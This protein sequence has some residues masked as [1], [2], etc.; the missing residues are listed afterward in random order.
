M[1][2]IFK[3]SIL[4][5]LTLTGYSFLLL[6]KTRFILFIKFIFI[7]MISSDNVVD[8]C[9]FVLMCLTPL[10]AILQLYRGIILL[11]KETGGAG[12]NHRPVPSH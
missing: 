10:S 5:F 3:K 12:E 2:V 1:N 8:F 4:Q 7:H 9:L 11:V 6:H